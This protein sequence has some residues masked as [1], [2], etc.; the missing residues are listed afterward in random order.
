MLIPFRYLT[1]IRPYTLPY[2]PNANISQ[3]QPITQ[4][5]AK[6]VYMHLTPQHPKQ[7]KKPKPEKHILLKYTIM[8][9]QKA[10]R[11]PND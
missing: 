11:H 1:A 6:H 8:T 10:K 4:T 9:K 2:Y 7:K 3:P 5:N